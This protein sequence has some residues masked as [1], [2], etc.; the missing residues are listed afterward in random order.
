MPAFVQGRST[1]DLS[2]VLRLA[3]SG[4]GAC[5][6]RIACS[7]GRTTRTAHATRSKPATQ[8]AC[9]C[10]VGDCARDVAHGYAPIH[11]CPCAASSRPAR[12]MLV[13]GSPRL[14]P[15]RSTGHPCGGSGPLRRCR[16][17][18][19]GR[20]GA[21]RTAVAHAAGDPCGRQERDQ[22][23][24]RRI[25]HRA[26]LRARCDGGAMPR[27][28]DA[29]GGQQEIRPA[30]CRL[31]EARGKAQAC[32]PVDGDLPIV[33]RHGKTPAQCRG[34]GFGSRGARRRALSATAW[35][36]SPGH[37]RPPA[38]RGR[39]GAWLPGLTPVRAAPARTRAGNSAGR[40]RVGIR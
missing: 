21:P 35:R 1:H 39:P 29:G 28:H 23:H 32:D 33:R 27:G 40:H 26:P 30:Q 8:A 36:A 4:R 31:P 17:P 15:L 9:G 10:T 22:G 38:R 3:G 14:R 6:H 34:P 12:H 11:A 2:L 16:L 37:V 19:D 25:T 24:A 18:L 13:L 7:R 5:G 20:Q